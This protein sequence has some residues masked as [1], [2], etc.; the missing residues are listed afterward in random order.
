MLSTALKKYATLDNLTFVLATIQCA[1]LVWFFYTGLGGALELVARV[2][3]I[4]LALQIL[5]MYQQDYFYKWLPP[6]ANH[7]LVAIYLGICAYSFLHFH[8]EFERIAIYA[9]GSFT[10]TDYVVGLLV[11]LLVMELT[12][13]AHPI[14]FWTNVF[15][16]AYTLWGF[17]SPIDFFWHPGTSFR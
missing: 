13:L 2:M 15:M 12:R 1:W 9:Q 10:Q 16:V 3:S 11:F 8:Y 7:L 17:L 4:A 6:L 14:L 5:F